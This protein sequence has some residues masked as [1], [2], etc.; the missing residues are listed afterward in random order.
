MAIKLVD[1]LKEGSNWTKQQNTN[2]LVVSI[3]SE[4]C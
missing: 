2:E 4:W 3:A 1:A